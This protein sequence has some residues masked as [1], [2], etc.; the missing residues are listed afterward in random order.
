MKKHLLKTILITMLVIGLMPIIVPPTYA[1]WPVLAWAA[2][3]EIAIDTAIDAV[4]D[5]FKETVKPEEVEK[6]RQ[7]VIKLETQLALSKQQGSYPTIKEFNAV[8]QLVANLN[9]VINKI[10]KRLDSVEARIAN[11][12]NDMASLRQALLN[13]PQPTVTNLK[14]P[15]DFKINYVYR[16]AGK[17]KAKTLVD[18]GTLHSGDYFKIIFTPDEDCYVYIFQVDSANQLFRL[19]PMKSFGGVT[20]DNFNAVK[21]GKTYYIPAEHQS[22]E[23]DNQI[24]PEMIYF[25]ATRQKDIVLEKQYQAF[26]KAQQQKN[27]VQSQLVQNQLT[28]TV[29]Q[30]KG[31]ASIKDDPTAAIKTWQ[32]QGQQLSV[33]Q[34]TLQ[35]MC[36]GCVNILTFQH[37]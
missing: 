21:S 14:K 26:Q 32:E 7:R 16:T 22:F 33:L 36:N 4:Q 1:G 28:E 11:L 13:I 8:K 12:E 2:V 6:L 31:I 23:L 35:D 27:P 18:G 25:V 15:L 5:L 30:K 3:R 19:F 34:N 10:G 20:V 9:N 17:G 37:Q 29:K 24:G